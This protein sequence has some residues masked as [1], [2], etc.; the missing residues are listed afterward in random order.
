MNPSPNDFV[1]NPLRREIHGSGE[2]T[3]RLIASLPAPAGL[4]DRVQAGLRAAPQ[5]GRIVIWRGPLRPP[6]G[7]MYGGIVRCAAA[8][9][10]VCVVAGGGWRIFSHVHPPGSA[11]VM[12]A[13]VPAGGNGFSSAG[14][15]RVPQ[16]LEGPVLTHP[17][18][19]PPEVNVVQKA[20]AQP[21]PGVSKKK[22]ITR[23]VAVPVQ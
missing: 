8:A 23:S 1:S 11:Q 12:P 20:P 17:V 21:T 4:S 18:S 6:F 15:K 3:L 13:P 7:W 19:A 9:A 14:A 10:I 5:A 22:R 2:D 16:T